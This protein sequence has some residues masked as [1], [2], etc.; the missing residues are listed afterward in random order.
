M[1]SCIIVDD[2]QHAVDILQEYIQK[3]PFLNLQYT[4]SNP[5][6]ALS[7]IQNND[8]D[9]VFLDIQMPDLTGIQFLKI[10]GNKCKFIITT[11]FS[12]YALEGY[13]YAVIDYLLKPFSFERFLTATQK[14]L[15]TL[16]V[17]TFQPMESIPSK[18]FV[19]IKSGVKG[20]MIK[21][22]LDDI[23]YI[24]GLKNYVSIITP[25]EKIIAYLNIKDLQKELPVGDFF[26]IHRSYIVALDKIKA[27]DGNQVIL[28]GIRDKKAT[29]P[30]GGTYKNSFFSLLKKKILG[31]KKDP[32]A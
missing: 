2:E 25:D 23:I 21:I 31:D 27:I 15:S 24:E 7:F 10:A 18:D 28:D 22:S 26:R 17:K 19:L 5:I 13:E 30:I 1:I 32:N 3:T 20:K 11:A 8:N 14:V 12:E 16:P 6:E 29:V 9:L 4:T